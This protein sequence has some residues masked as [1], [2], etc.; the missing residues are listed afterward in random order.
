MDDRPLPTSYAFLRVKSTLHVG[1]RNCPPTGVPSEGTTPEHFEH[2][3]ITG[4]SSAC[5]VRPLA[6]RANW[7]L[8]FVLYNNSGF[9]GFPIGAMI[10]MFS[11][12]SCNLDN[13][14]Q[15]AKLRSS[16]RRLGSTVA[17]EMR[18]DLRDSN[19][20]LALGLEA[21]SYLELFELF[22]SPSPG[23]RNLDLKS[24]SFELSRCPV[25]P[26]PRFL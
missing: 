16:C 4:S 5:R 7:T 14:M 25:L 20:I 23:K 3:S 11:T 13:T 26:S 10:S 24:S 2:G 19:P 8:N 1:H 6:R 9:A 22:E 12:W 18:C 21:N 17:S 15:A